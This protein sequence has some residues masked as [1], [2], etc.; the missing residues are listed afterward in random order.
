MHSLSTGFALGF[1]PGVE[2][3]IVISS[4]LIALTFAASLVATFLAVRSAAR[5]WELQQALQSFKPLAAQS[6][7]TR[8]N[9]LEQTLSLVANRV[10]MT[11]V[12]NAVTHTD[13]DKDGEPDAK[14]DPERWRAWKN[15]Q[16]RAGQF[17]Q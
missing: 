17:N 7:E 15:A 12:R 11:K 8:L 4:V 13:R 10:K 3:W 1:P 16:L 9:E 2:M 6:L 14:S 5:V